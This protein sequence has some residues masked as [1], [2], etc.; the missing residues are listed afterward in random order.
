MD[1]ETLKKAKRY[2]ERISGVSEVAITNLLNNGNFET[3]WSTSNIVADSHS[4][5]NNVATFLASDYDGRIFTPFN[6]IEGHVYYARADVKT[7]APFIT[8]L[9]PNVLS[10]VHPGNDQWVTLQGIGTAPTTGTNT[11][12]IR[13][14]KYLLFT[15]TFVRRVMLIDLTAAFG[16]GNEPRLH[17]VESALNRIENNWFGGTKRLLFGEGFADL[18]PLAGKRIVCFGDSVTGGGNYPRVIADRTKAVVT[19]AG[20]GG[21]RMA[22]H[23]NPGYDAFS[24]YRLADGIATGDWSLQYTHRGI[25]GA[26]YS[27]LSAI[28]W[29]DIDIITIAFGQND[30]ASNVG[31]GQD[32]D[33]DG[34]TFKGAINYSVE[35]ILSA[36]PHIKIA[37]LCPTWRARITSEDSLESDSNPNSGGIFLIEYVDAIKSRAAHFKLPVLDL[38]RESGIN[39][40]T[41]EFYLSDGLHP[42]DAGYELL[43][44]KIAG[45]LTSKF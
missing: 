36:Y 25:G 39:S 31:I 24:M 42:T 11:L 32:S 43:G 34:T 13:D 12:S 2:A 4:V 33:N 23:G 8:L 1:L 37:F 15:E 44:H 19:N 35:K 9:I 18:L 40:L 7:D 16:P 41:N 20:V 45:F 17:E 14:R 27:K 30:F 38:Y 26:A 3:T 10:D 5:E 22:A 21:T 29:A 6:Q 28:D